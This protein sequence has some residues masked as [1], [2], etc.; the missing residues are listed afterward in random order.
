MARAFRPFPDRMPLLPLASQTVGLTLTTTLLLD[1][2]QSVSARMLT[3]SLAQRLESI[4]LMR[5]PWPARQPAC[6]PRPAIASSYR[7]LLAAPAVG[8]ATIPA[9]EQ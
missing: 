6:I 5:S 7:A 4:C 3:N 8:S 9:P 2:E 1:Q